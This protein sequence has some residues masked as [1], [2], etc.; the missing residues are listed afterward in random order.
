MYLIHLPLIDTRMYSSKYTIVFSPLE[1]VRTNTPET[2]EVKII[3]KK[4]VL[5][6]VVWLLRNLDDHHGYFIFLDVDVRNTIRRNRY[7]DI[8]ER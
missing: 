3:T 5:I 6:S 4:T 8:I 1:N 2:S 7:H